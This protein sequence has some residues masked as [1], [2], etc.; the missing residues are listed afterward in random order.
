M[1]KSLLSR[2]VYIFIGLV[3]VCS[4]M[5]RA[6]GTIGTITTVA[7]AGPTG[8]SGDG[9]PATSATLAGPTGVAFDAA[10]NLYIADSTNSRIRKVTP[11]GTISTVAGTG[12]RGFAGDGG[13]ATS[14]QLRDP[15]G[16]ALDAAGNLFIADYSNNRVRKVLLALAVTV[17]PNGTV[18]NGSFASGT[19]PLAP[20]TIAAIFGSNLNDGSS[21]PFSSFGSDGKLL[22]TLGGAS[23]TFNGFS[24][25]IFS[26][27]PGQLNVQLPM[28]LAG[29]TSATVVVT[30]GGQASAPQTVPLG[31]F[32]PGIFSTNNQ[33]TGQGA[34]QIANTLI[35]AAP[36]GSISGA[37]TRPANRGEF[38]TIYA[39]GLG[40]VTTPP[41]TGMAASGDPLSTTT[42]MPQ[43]TIGGIPANI[44]FAGRSPGFVGLDQV[45]AQVP[46][47]APAGNAIPVALSIGGVSSNTVTIAVQ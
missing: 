3:L 2:C 23:V 29:A 13:P 46:A 47:G 4:S 15:Y 31:P 44:S 33:G 20:G 40:A 35:F 1:I 30:V 7:G 26:S 17:Y 34:I 21:N 36:A 12:T 43:V 19:N 18:N 41:A 25:P 9:G 39:T 24:A 27:F 10:G 42:T 11:G 6:Q 5:A 22:A 32:S 8:F 14:A 38:L 16:V 37:Q 28:E 45:N